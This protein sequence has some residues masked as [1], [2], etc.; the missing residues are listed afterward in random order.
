MAT[1]THIHIPYS[2]PSLFATQS[3]GPIPGPADE[4]VTTSCQVSPFIVRRH[5]CNGTYPT[6][7]AQVKEQQIRVENRKFSQ[8]F[9]L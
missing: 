2:L 8:V 5:P 1:Q 9:S 4:A 6:V 7:S 3:E